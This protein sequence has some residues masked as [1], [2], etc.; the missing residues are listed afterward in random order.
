MIMTELHLQLISH[1][2]SF[3]VLITKPDDR[4]AEFGKVFSGG[5][6]SSAGRLGFFL[7]FRPTAERKEAGEFSPT[8][9]C[10]TAEI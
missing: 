6:R 10:R 9:S 1:E 3:L 8:P 7:S 5:R 2:E 4:R